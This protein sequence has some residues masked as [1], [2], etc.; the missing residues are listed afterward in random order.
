MPEAS[1]LVAFLA[2]IVSF[3]S[4]CILPIIPGFLSYLS[5]VGL[6]DR[7]ANARLKTMLNALFFVLGF[8]LVFSALGLLLNQALG[9]IT[10]DLRGLLSQLGGI[11]IIGFGLFLLGVLKLQ[12]LER[13]YRLPVHKTK[14]SFLT[15]FLFGAG[16]A[17]GWSPCISAVLGSI[18][19]LAVASPGMAF[20][21]LF[22]YSLGLGIPFLMCGFFASEFASMLSRHGKLIFYF[23]KFVGIL[24]IL[25]GSLV[26]TNQLARFSDF[27]YVVDMLK[28]AR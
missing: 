5:G 1:I 19:T 14:Y 11:V 28:G 3:F 24:L 18:L 13:E 23:N 10:A 17:A 12:F 25:L 27:S 15:S 8:S 26:L 4:P 21:M 9:G 2:G 6:K 22:V 16:F 20:A 7:S